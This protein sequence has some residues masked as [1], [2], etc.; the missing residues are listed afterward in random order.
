M[1]SSVVSVINYKGGVG[2]TTLAANIGADMAARGR[3]VLLVD[4]DP[5]ASL[6]FSLFRVEEWEAQLAREQTILQWFD[7]FLRAGTVGPLRTYVVSPPAVNEVVQPLGGQLDLL[8]SHLG[9]IE[10]D[11]DLAARLGG[12]QFQ[13]SH[14]QFLPIHRLLADALSDDGFARYDAVLIDCAPNFNM[15]T[16]TAIV[17]SDYLVVP[18]RPDYLSS[19]GVDYH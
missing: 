6:T 10:V 5:Q 9:L 8:A 16:R 11:L 19:L 12:A 4:M 17:A 14:P 2:K 7:V 18:T 13:K 15:V 1:P 3:R